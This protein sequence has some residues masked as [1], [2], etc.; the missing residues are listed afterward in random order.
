MFLSFNFLNFSVV[1]TALTSNVL[2]EV[3]TS[4]LCHTLTSLAEVE[5]GEGC[6][7]F[8][9]D[10]S[11]APSAPRPAKG[12]ALLVGS[13]RDFS[14]PGVFPCGYSL[15]SPPCHCSHILLETQ[16]IHITPVVEVSE[17][18][19]ELIVLIIAAGV[20]RHDQANSLLSHLHGPGAWAVVVC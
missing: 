17:Q 5:C 4:H 9:L 18:V 14:C 6:P 13:P 20:D 12:G 11:A 10:S 8:A 2:M 16:V 19:G 3:L 1:A 15:L 7:R